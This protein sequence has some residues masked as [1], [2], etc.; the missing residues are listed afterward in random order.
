M[1]ASA[2]DPTVVLKFQYVEADYVRAVRTHE[3]SSLLWRIDIVAILMF[4]AIGCYLRHSSIGIFFICASVAMAFMHFA[5]VTI[6]PRISFRRQPK[7]QQP[8]ELR[9]SLDGLHF[10]TK[11]VDS[12][13]QWNIYSRALADDCS[14]LLY[15]GKREFTVIPTRVFDSPDQRE[16]FERLLTQKIPRI[17][18]R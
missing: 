1:D 3:F 10:Q 2:D 13:L 7:F 5:S 6:I 12:R 16:V 11:G 17:R 4:A 8:Y 18:R 15:H 14:Y 9:F